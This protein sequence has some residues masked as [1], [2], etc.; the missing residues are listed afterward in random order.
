MRFHCAVEGFL[1][2]GMR[3]DA[4]GRRNLA[5]RLRAS[6]SGSGVEERGGLEVDGWV[7]ALG[8][9]KI[10]IALLARIIVGI[11]NH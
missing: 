7:G 2:V 11:S 9:V 1:K 3:A 8:E 4:W 10:G 5:R 6:I